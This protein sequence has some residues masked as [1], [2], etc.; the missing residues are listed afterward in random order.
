M[1]IVKFGRSCHGMVWNGLV[2]FSQNSEAACRFRVVIYPIWE[3]IWTGE[4]IRLVGR[5][6]G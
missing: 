6:D 1:K 5:T 2:C 4:Q 3:V